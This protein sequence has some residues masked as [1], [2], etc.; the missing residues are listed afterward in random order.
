MLL[1]S[2]GSK[3]RMSWEVVSDSLVSSDSLLEELWC[4]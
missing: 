3:S 2:V 4:I 1:L